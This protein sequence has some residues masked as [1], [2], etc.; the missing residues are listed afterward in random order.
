MSPHLTEDQNPVCSRGNVILRL[1]SSDETE[2]CST[3][4][5]PHLI[6]E[7]RQYT[8]RHWESTLVGIQCLIWRPQL[9]VDMRNNVGAVGNVYAISVS[10]IRGCYN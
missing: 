8:T 6:A 1:A 10:H 5:L 2:A 7:H 9:R 3:R 4:I